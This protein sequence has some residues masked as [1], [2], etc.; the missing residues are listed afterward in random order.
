MRLPDKG[1]IVS[2]QADG[3][4][5]L[6]TP[7]VLEALCRSVLIGGAQGLRLANLEVI[8]AMR[9]QFPELPIVGLTKPPKMPAN[10]QQ[11]VYITPT[12]EDAQA[13]IDA[14]AH[15]VA[16]DATLRLRPVPL[17][18]WVRALRDT[19]PGAKLWAD[20]DTLEAGLNAAQLGFDVISTT[21]SGYTVE[22]A[23]GSDAGPDFDL[24]A[25]LVAQVPVPVVLEGRVWTPE[26]VRHG[27]ALGA[28]AVVVGS[29]ITRPHLVTRRFLAGA[30]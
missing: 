19:R 2:V 7:A 16:T 18:D 21:M 25:A 6:N 12:V 17:A 29:A 15:W 27:L 1:L 8:A 11:Q 20:V 9:A 26:E 3:D 13:V 10:A 14:G 28:A 22:S 4:E 5:P 24:L 23:K 30:Q